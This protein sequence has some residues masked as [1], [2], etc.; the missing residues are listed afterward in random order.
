MKMFI[1]SSSHDPQKTCKQ[2]QGWK[3]LP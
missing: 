3:P 2:S 1:R